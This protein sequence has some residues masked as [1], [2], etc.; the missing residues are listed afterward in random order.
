M[1]ANDHYTIIS[2]DCHAGGSHEM[3]R[4]YLDPDLVDEFDAW[5]EKYKNPFRDLQDGGRIRNWDDEKRIGDL[6]ADGIVAEVVFPN[7]VPPFFPSFV[8]FARPPRPEEFRQ[9]LGGIRAHNRW[10]AEWCGRFP[11]RRAGIGQI[12]LNDVDE[13]LRDIQWIHDNGLRGG[14]LISAV[15]PDVDYIKPLYDPIYDPI[16]QACS[17]LGLPVNSHGGTGLPDYGRYPA[18]ALLFITEVQ[19][20]SQRPFCQLL[21]GGV[22]ERFP[23]LKFVMTE[24]GG[25]WMPPMLEHFDRVL[26]QIRDTGR[27]GEMR[28]RDEDVLPKS[29][30][31]YF[32]QN[33]WMGVSQPG[34]DD[35]AAAYDIGL[36]RFMWG[37][38]YPHNEG[39]GPFTR[40]HLR[41]RFSTMPE[42]DLRQILA[43]SAAELYGFDL[44]A[45]APIAEK[46]GP[47]VAEI[48]QP[49]LDLP[50]NPNEALLRI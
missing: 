36:D 47:T 35:A 50:E 6:E 28:Y 20:Y 39:T 1:A 46:V 18:S 7:T 22:F 12:F 3:Y 37:A 9:R 11:E 40:E 31:E 2:S 45:L 25:A 44:D 41:Q 48:A 4:S 19:F 10:M 24:M 29:A 13:A 42:A 34:P 17:D 23:H 32:R 49:L 33:C 8:L 27:M 21:F 15:P 26:G 16:W 14:I 30:T 5:R 43:G 38:D